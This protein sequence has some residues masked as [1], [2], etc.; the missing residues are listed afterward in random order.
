MNIVLHGSR[1]VVK[2]IVEREHTAIPLL[3]SLE[4]LPPPPS[5][6]QIGKTAAVTFNL[7]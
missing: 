3:T 4:P 5:P 2:Q 1:K 6:H 7:A